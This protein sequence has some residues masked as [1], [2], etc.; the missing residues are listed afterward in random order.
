MVPDEQQLRP[1]SDGLLPQVVQREG[2]GQG[3]FVD[4]EQLSG[5]KDSPLLLPPEG[6]ASRSDAAYS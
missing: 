5:A 1:G 6:R 4:D 2:A 3:C